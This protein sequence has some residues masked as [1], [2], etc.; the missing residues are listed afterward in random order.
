M[1]MSQP[2]AVGDFGHQLIFSLV[3]ITADCL[4]PT[5]VKLGLPIA[6]VVSWAILQDRAGDRYVLVRET[7][8]YYSNGS[9]ALSSAGGG[10][11]AS[12]AETANLW[13]GEMVAGG[14]EH[15]YELKS[16]DG[17]FGG[18]ASAQLFFDDKDGI[19]RYEERGF[20]SLV[21]RRNA[22]GHQF[23]DPTDGQFIVEQAFPAEGVIGG[24]AVT[25]FL[26]LDAQ[27]FP[28]GINYRN[29]PFCNDGRLLAWIYLH[30]IYEDGGWDEGSII[31]GREGYQLAW[32]LNE[33]GEFSFSGNV[34]AQFDL[35]DDGF[36]LEMHI[37]FHDAKTGKPSVWHWTLKPGSEMVDVAKK[38]P[39]M[40]HK[41]SCEGFLVR[42]GETRM[43]TFASAW[44]EFHADGRH[45]AFRIKRAGR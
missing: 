40:K 23:F 11:L 13:R 37:R 30:N 39:R 35:R 36:P 15:Q 9:W 32:I 3:N 43:L 44:P 18:A 26:G 34:D 8:G 21:G 41:R 16:A 14:E 42:E 2:R 20:A 1:D 38:S 6:N 28:I 25:G 31:M 29:S 33:K 4:R 22:P 45:D 5:S 12:M 7:Y 10:G 17:A 19:V 24:R 27:Y